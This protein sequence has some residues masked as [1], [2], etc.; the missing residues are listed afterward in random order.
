MPTE[1]D[2]NSR[3]GLGGYTGPG[4]VPTLLAIVG[5]PHF[6]DDGL[7]AYGAGFRTTV[8]QHLSIDLAAYYNDYSSQET[9]EPTAPFFTNTPAPPHLVLPLTYENLMHGESHGFELAVNWKTTARWT[10]SPGYA[11]EQIHMH[12]DPTS[13]DTGSVL[14]AEGSSP[15]QSAQLRSHL[16]VKHGIS[17]DASAYFVDR[18]RSGEIPAYTRVDTGLTWRWTE[19]LSCSVAGQNLVRD[20]HLEFVDDTGSVISTLVKR[21]AYAKF[22]WQF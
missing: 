1:L 18:L 8:L 17:W 13:Q 9:T 15:V 3:I 12:L 16:D 14:N 19:H 7:I 20:H 10:L 6:H 11:F 4:G 5:N 21:G 2:T 22:T